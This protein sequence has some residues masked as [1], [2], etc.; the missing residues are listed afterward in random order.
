MAAIGSDAQSPA[1]LG[2][3]VGVADDDTAKVDER[4]WMLEEATESVD[5]NVDDTN[6]EEVV[7]EK[8]A[9]E[10]ELACEEVT[11]DCVEDEADR[12]ELELSLV[13]VE[14]G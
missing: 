5:D 7:S 12:E 2:V 3:G 10:D 8:I 14:A 13:E 11:L 1:A 9:V 6:N 4:S